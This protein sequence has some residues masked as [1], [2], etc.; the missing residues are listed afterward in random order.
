[1]AYRSGLACLGRTNEGRSLHVE[2]ETGNIYMSACTMR[3]RRLSL[4]S[5]T[6]HS[7]SGMRGTLIRQDGYRCVLSSDIT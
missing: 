2:K 3:E 4:R 7:L 6:I 5:D 1:M